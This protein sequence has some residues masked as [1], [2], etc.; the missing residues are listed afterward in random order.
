MCA[1]SGDNDWDSD[2]MDKQSSFKTLKQHV[3]IHSVQIKHSPMITLQKDYLIEEMSSSKSN[4]LATIVGRRFFVQN[5][6]EVEH[7]SRLR[8][9]N[10]PDH[11]LPIDKVMNMKNRDSILEAKS[12]EIILK[13]METS[14]EGK[15][16]S[17]STCHKRVPNEPCKISQQNNGKINDAIYQ[18]WSENEVE[19]MKVRKGFEEQLENRRKELQVYFNDQQKSMESEIENHL[20]QMKCQLV[21]KEKD[22]VQRLV[23]EMEDMKTENLKKLRSELEMCYEKERQD[24]LENLKTELNERKQ[25]L[26]ELRN[27]ELQVL[28][29]EHEN[30]LGRDRVIKIA[31]H[32]L[33]EQHNGKIDAMKKELEK[34]FGDLKN[35]L[36]SEQR[37]KVSKIKED[38]EKCLA[39]ILRDFRVDVSIFDNFD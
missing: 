5:V 23:S 12:G 36:R 3:G 19:I 37:E 33:T 38:H 13:N 4:A 9:E 17:V 27:R 24:I 31:E 32:D 6:S 28:E 1:G 2:S 7:M 10:V 20:S 21:K 14:D 34:E 29:H 18:I 25:E 35:A 22:E 26:L 30:T 11:H 16:H 39:D 15:L 8:T